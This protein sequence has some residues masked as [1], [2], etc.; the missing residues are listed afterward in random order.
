[1]YL[2]LDG[3]DFSLYLI[4]APLTVICLT[5]GYETARS[6]KYVEYPDVASFQDKLDDPT[7]CV[8]EVLTN[9]MRRLYLDIEYI[10]T[11]QPDLITD[12]ITAFITF[13]E[14]DEDIQYCITKNEHSAQHEGLSYHVIFSVAMDYRSMLK[15][16]KTFHKAYPQYEEYVDDNVYTLNRLFR[17]P[18]QG[19]PSKEGV[20]HEDRHVLI[21]GDMSMAF[22]Q[23]VSNLRELHDE[24]LPEAARVMDE[25]IAT[26]R[27]GSYRQQTRDLQDALIL[28]TTKIME[29]ISQSRKE[30]S[31]SMERIHSRVDKMDEVMQHLLDKIGEQ[32]HM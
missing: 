20:D 8:L 5:E 31:D 15:C 3:T 21:K 19:K 11:D 12:I 25:N 4:M 9:R 7:V 30:M 26:R 28:F 24:D 13:M 6:N 17:L 14:F 29:E 23:D 10:P 27:K 32:K 1:M 2:P 22:I 18:E 16:V